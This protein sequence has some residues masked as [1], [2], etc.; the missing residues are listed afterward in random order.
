MIHHRFRLL[1]LCL[2]LTALFLGGCGYTTP[3]TQTVRVAIRG[4]VQDVDALKL[5]PDLRYLRV[6]VRG[7]VVLM[8]LGYVEPHAEGEIQTW[9]SSEGELMRLQNGRLVATAGLE[10]DWRAVR[11]SSLPAWKEVSRQNA[12]GAATDYRRERDEMPGYRFGIV[13]SV[14]LYAVAVPPNSKLVGVRAGDFR[15]FEEAVRGQ[16]DGLPS[17]RYAL[18]VIDGEP[19]VIYGEQCLSLDLCLA[20]QTWPA[21]Q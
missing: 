18:R 19:R 14:S 12:A 1:S 17:A 3:I 15:W 6:T 16:A 2:A 11:N 13:E 10:T 9:Y 4:P 7:R 5:N 20:W 21:A 8:V